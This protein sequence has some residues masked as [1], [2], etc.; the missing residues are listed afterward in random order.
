MTCDITM[1]PPTTHNGPLRHFLQFKDFSSAE[2]AYVQYSDVPHGS[3]GYQTLFAV[4]LTLFVMTLA[5][6]STAIW[7]RERYRSV[8][9]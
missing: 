2:I 3:L 8:Y 9:S 4:G 1:T 5:L 6:N 7:L